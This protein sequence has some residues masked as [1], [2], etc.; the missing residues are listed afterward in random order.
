MVFK[1]TFKKSFRKTFRGNFRRRKFGPSIKQKIVG[2]M[3]PLEE[4]EMMSGK[5]VVDT[6]AIINKKVSSLASK[7]LNGLILIPNAAMAEL[8]NLAN[9]GNEIG[10]DGLEE[11][12][13]LHNFKKLQVRF[14][15]SRPSEHQIKYAK[16][17][18]IDAL[19]RGLA[20]ENKAILITADVVQAKSAEA[21]GLKV[22]FIKTKVEKP[23]PKF[24][25]FKK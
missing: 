24:L 9:R 12:A 13:R 20:Y 23:K 25:F 17:G 16:S 19:I 3:K 4:K 18:E 7:G 22:L 1:K 2:K 21:Y 11:I 10:F 15:G 14:V 8:E 6:S 5:F